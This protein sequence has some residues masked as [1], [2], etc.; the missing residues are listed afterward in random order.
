[1]KNFIYI[2]FGIIILT[3]CET[4]PCECEVPSN[5]GT[6]TFEVKMGSN[7]GLEVFDAIDKAW[8]ALDYEALKSYVS[9]DAVMKFADGKVAVGGDEFVSMIQKE[10]E[11][12]GEAEY[13]NWSTDY[14]FSLA[15]TSDND[16]STNVDEGDWVNAQ[17][18]VELKSPVD[19]DIRNVFYEFYHIIDGKVVS[20]DQFKRGEKE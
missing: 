8:G 2:L 3:G 5:G 16:E 12:W 9:E 11:E 15:T 13:V 6:G 4:A 7:D 1:M 10:V 20:W 18:T 19:G 14:K 17:F